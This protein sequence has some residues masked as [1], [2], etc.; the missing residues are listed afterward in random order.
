MIT[1]IV[2]LGGGIVGC[3]IAWH[4]ASRDGAVSV[5][6]IERD[7]S[8]QRAATPLGNGGIRQ[9][10]SLPE[11]IAMAQY[12]LD[13]YANF[14]ERLAVDGEPAPIGFKRHGYL[15]LSDG[16]G[17]EQME[18]NQKFQVQQGVDAQLLDGP[19]LNALFPSVSPDGVD[20]A[21]YSPDDAWIDPY[22][23]LQGLRTSAQS[24]GVR[25]VTAEITGWEGDGTA[26]RLVRL[27]DGTSIKAD[28]FVNACG[29]WAAEVG[30]MIG[31]HLPVE[32]MSR[33]SYFFKC[34][35]PLEPLPF[36]KSE[37]DLAIRPEGTGYV[38]GVPNWQETAGW[39]FELS[40]TW[41][42]EVVWPALARRVP[43]ME[44]IKLERSWRGHY[45]RNALDYTAIIGPWVG[46]LE[47]VYLANGFSGH[48]IMHA[49][50]TGRA[51]AELILN[52][53]FETLD[54]ARFGYQR[55]IDNAPYREIGIV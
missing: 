54:L 44:E 22:A 33:E 51:V 46:G 14:E 17:A 26:A 53:S 12:S 27:Q 41:F 21:V 42:E 19:A 52:G 8:Y 36:L 37:T 30:A 18:N 5:T 45:A 55:I 3:S 15:F 20:V 1:D 16:G 39:N 35:K 49:P 11:N 2:I 28:T 34:G 9:L 38:G 43:A 29:A 31:L 32:P 6:V 4:L 23:A 10:F 50:A 13:F 48:G 24:Q 47:N 7:P 25:F 40:Q